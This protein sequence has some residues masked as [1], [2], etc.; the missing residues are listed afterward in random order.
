M[1]CVFCQSDKL[2]VVKTNKQFNE[3]EYTCSCSRIYY[4]NDNIIFYQLKIDK[5]IFTGNVL[6]LSTILGK[7]KGK[8]RFMYRGDFIDINKSNHSYDK[9]NT[10]KVFNIYNKCLKLNGF[11]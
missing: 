1:S 11:Q 3:I 9:L 4:R 6:G 10:T 2:K 7:E 5:N 8:I